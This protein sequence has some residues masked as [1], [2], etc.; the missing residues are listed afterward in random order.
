M[1]K[2][3]VEIQKA[4]EE[5]KNYV[6][7]IL[8]Y[9]E[10]WEKSLKNILIEA[11]K[12]IA[13]LS[14]VKI[15]Y[16]VFDDIKNLE[17]V[18][19]SAENGNSNIFEK[20]GNFLDQILKQN[21]YLGFSQQFNGSILVWVNYPIYE[22]YVEMKQAL[23]LDT[24]SPKEI[25]EELIKSYFVKYMNEMLLWEKQYKVRSVGYINRNK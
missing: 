21:G 5:Y 4:T 25:N 24:I 23:T 8:E 19:L 22:N 1:N 9:Q 10:Y 2:L 13:K 18:A 11:S 3:D 16:I 14:S 6:A 15:N 20:K 7:L 12:S 17:T